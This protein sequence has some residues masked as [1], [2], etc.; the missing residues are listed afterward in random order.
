M[1]LFDP[2]HRASGIAM[3]VTGFSFVVL[4][5]EAL[6]RSAA[7]W[8]WDYPSRSFPFEHM[9]LAV[10]VTLGLFLIW[11]ARDPVR[12]LPLINFTIVSGVLHATAMFIDASRM[13]SMA[14]HLTPSGDVVGTYLA[15][16]ILTLFHPALTEFISR[17]RG[18]ERQRSGSRG[19]A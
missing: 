12:S 16:V 3:I 14:S 5:P 17:R 15:P 10:Y 8:V 11:G 1:R 6:A 2:N 19:A 9:L 13:P 7:G 18:R 4:Y